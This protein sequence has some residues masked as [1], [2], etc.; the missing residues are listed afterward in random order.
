MLMDPLVRAALD[1]GIQE[2]AIAGGVSA[3][4]GLRARLKEAEGQHGWR[5]TFPMAY[6]TDNA[7]MIAAVGWLDFLE[8]R[9]APWTPRHPPIAE[10][11]VWHSERQA[12]LG[13]C[14]QGSL[15]APQTTLPDGRLSRVFL[16]WIV[17]LSGRSCRVLKPVISLLSDSDTVV[18]DGLAHPWQMRP[19]GEAFDADFELGC[20]GHLGKPCH[21]AF[22]MTGCNKALNLTWMSTSSVTFLSGKQRV[23]T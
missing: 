14:A 3:S 7:A 9:Q 18:A 17:L 8:Q 19:R 11:K 12:K 6:C 22:S 23:A 2:V 10:L 13:F 15:D 21:R 1:T 16:S 5:I 4:S 20:T